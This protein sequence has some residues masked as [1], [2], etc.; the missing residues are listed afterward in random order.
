[1]PLIIRILLC[2][3]KHTTT[4]YEL[5][6]KQFLI[7]NIQYRNKEKSQL[8]DERY[9]TPSKMSQEPVQCTS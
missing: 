2:N 1:M 8:K 9:D 5:K 4:Q 6:K 7:T 3:R